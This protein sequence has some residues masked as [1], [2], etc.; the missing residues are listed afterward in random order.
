MHAQIN[1]VK[2]VITTLNHTHHSKETAKMVDDKYSDK[3]A[4]SKSKETSNIARMTGESIKVP[5]KSVENKPNKTVD[6]ENI[7]TI[8]DLRSIQKQDPFM[9]YSIPGDR[10]ATV[11]MQDIDMSN[12]TGVLGNPQKAQDETPQEVSQKVSRST[13]VSFECHPDL[14]LADLLN[15]FH[16][17]DFEDVGEPLDMDL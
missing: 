7:T 11:L 2:P 6:L 9:Y 13:C 15:D 8:D 5:I 3:V 14:L 4:S 16:G 10:S 1:A 12:L 17:L